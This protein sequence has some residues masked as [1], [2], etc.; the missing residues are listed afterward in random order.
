MERY[1]AGSYD[2]NTFAIYDGA[3]VESYG[4]FTLTEAQN[5]AEELNSEE[6]HELAS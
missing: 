5:R 6:P 3:E 4:Y 2:D 1:T